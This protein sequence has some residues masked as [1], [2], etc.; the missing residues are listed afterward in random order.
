MHL[1]RTPRKE[2]EALAGSIINL[3]E[4]IRLCSNCYAMSDTDI[5]QICS[6]PVRDASIVCVVENASEM[7]AIEKSGSFTG[8]YHILQGLLSPMDGVGPDDI[9]IRELLDKAKHPGIKEI[10]LATGTSL[11]GDT[12]ASYIAEQLVSSSARVTRI[13]SG[14]PMGGDIKYV[15]QLTLKRAMETRHEL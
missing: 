7:I 14:V 6:N 1:L 4:K 9:R 3:K 15:D 2:A 12:T 11:E 5:C 13:A 10:I 8:H